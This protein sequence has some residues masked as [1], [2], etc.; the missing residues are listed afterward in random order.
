L[1]L[2]VPTMVEAI[3]EGIQVQDMNGADEGTS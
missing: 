3:V 1:I 2:P